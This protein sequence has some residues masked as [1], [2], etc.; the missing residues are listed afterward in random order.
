MGSKLAHADKII[1]KWI[2]CR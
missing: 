2:L 1:A